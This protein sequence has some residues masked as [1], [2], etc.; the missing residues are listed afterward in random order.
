MINAP[1]QA[2]KPKTKFKKG[3]VV[4]LNDS[5]TTY[6]QS[7]IFAFPNLNK[8]PYY[9]DQILLDRIKALAAAGDYEQ[10]Y[11]DLR[12]YVKNFGIDNFHR[13]TKLIWDLAKLS[14]KEGP[15]GEAVLLYKL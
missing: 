12:D 4:Q 3:G 2:Q 13:D 9:R 10:E 8:V 11:K 5:L 1:L 7:D 6:S 14:E 15:A